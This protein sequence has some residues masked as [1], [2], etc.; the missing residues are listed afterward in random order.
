LYLAAKDG[1]HDP[2]MFDDPGMP[3]EGVAFVHMHHHPGVRTAHKRMMQKLSLRGEL[4]LIPGMRSAELFDDKMAQARHLSRWMPRTHVFH[5]PHSARSFIESGNCFPFYSKAVEGTNSH[6]VRLVETYDAAK[7]EIKFAFS[8]RGLK[9]RYGQ[10]Q[11]GYLL[12]QEVIPNN[13]Y[14]L[15]VVSIGRKRMVLRRY[16][17]ERRRAEPIN[18]VDDEIA[19]ALAFSGRFF[20]RESLPWAV[21]DLVRDRE[22]GR[23]YVLECS[24]HWAMEA[25]AACNFIDCDVV[26]DQTGVDV[27]KVLL[28]EIE[29]GRMGELH[30]A[31]A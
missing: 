29:L 4:L 10:K 11:I 27:W 3:D 14:D 22:N 26:T 25:F 24:A 30:E 1:G 9:A 2:I 13:E 31:A 18:Y 28:K 20:E 15:R 23:W 17:D 19:S 6:N 16:N 7:L 5:T 8:D 12:W 21:A